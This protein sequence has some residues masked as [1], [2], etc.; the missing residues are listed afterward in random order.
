[1][2]IENKTYLRY[3]RSMN[4]FWFNEDLEVYENQSSV[5]FSIIATMIR[6]TTLIM[7]VIVHRAFYKLMKR[8]PGRAINDMIYPYMVSFLNIKH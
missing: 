6:F 2:S 4:V 3:D 7:A 1:M 5:F 8:L